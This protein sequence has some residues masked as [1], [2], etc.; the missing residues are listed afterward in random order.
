MK[1][2]STFK[3][4]ILY[5]SMAH[6]RV[7]VGRTRRFSDAGYKT[8][9]MNSRWWNAMEAIAATLS[10]C[11]CL[12]ITFQKLTETLKK[13]SEQGMKQSTGD[14]N[15]LAACIIAFDT[16]YENTRRCLELL[17]FVCRC[18]LNAERSHFK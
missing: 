11:G 18:H 5:G 1:L 9:W 14:S 7:D 13:L 10:M 17:H 16:I 3:L 6:F 4:V 12:V 2:L 15:S 8:C